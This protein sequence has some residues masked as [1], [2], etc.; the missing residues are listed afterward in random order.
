V[1]IHRGRQLSAELCGIAMTSIPSD[2]PAAYAIG[3]ADL[4][5]FDDELA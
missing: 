1:V 3:I 4:S 5:H 2:G